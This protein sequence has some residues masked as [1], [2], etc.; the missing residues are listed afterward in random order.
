M[1]TT[2]EELKRIATET[3]YSSKEHFKTADWMGLSLAG[4]ISIP[5]VTSLI[6]I[7]FDFNPFIQQI[8][9]FTGIL[10][11]VL[12]LNSALA[13]NRERADKSI[14]EHMDL[15]NKYLAIHKEIRVRMADAGSV[16]T[17]MLAEFQ[18]RISDLDLKTARNRISFVGRWWAKCKIV[19][20]MD[21]DWLI[22][23]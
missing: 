13:N 3:A 1:T 5:M 23:K 19:E 22:D 17:D 12:A 8:L 2:S 10:F 4:Y 14:Q 21:L 20:E 18:R 11:S 7:F 6:T 15:G 16:T 9:A